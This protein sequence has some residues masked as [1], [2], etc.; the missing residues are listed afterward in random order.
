M[1]AAVRTARAGSALRHVASEVVVV[2]DIGHSTEWGHALEGIDT[3]I[4]LAGRAHVIHDSSPDPLAEFREVNVG[5]TLRLAQQ[6]APKVRRL[7]YL[8]SIGV[9]G[10]RTVDAPFSGSSP[11]APT[12]SYAI[13]KYEAEQGLWG[14]AGRT[15]LEVVVLRP[16][17]VYGP[18]CPG[19]FRRLLRLADSGIPLPLASIRNARSFIY[20][21]NLV[22]AL[23][24]CAE[25]PLARGRT[26][27]IDDGLAVSTPDLVRT[28]AALLRRKIILFPCPVPIL[29]LIGRT[30]GQSAAISRLTDSLQI[31]GSAIRSELGWQPICPMSEGLKQTVH[32]YR[33]RTLLPSASDHY[34]G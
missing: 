22:S 15:K 3:V 14:L 18:N 19:N 24:M 11:V 7:V 20:V 1:R 5:G 12:D 17:L 31:D 27:L 8:S 21:D 26:Y 16:P 30:I 28:L 6:A 9:N 32:W 23:E 25:Q 13:S 34:G 29:S 4:H 10:T 2:G 33:T